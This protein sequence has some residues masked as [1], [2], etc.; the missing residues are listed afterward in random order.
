M[1]DRLRSRVDSFIR[2][3]SIVGFLYAV[4]KKF[5]EDRAGQL[6]ALVA[7]YGFFSLFPLLL[8]LITLLGIV[9]R[10]NPE[11]QDSILQ[12]ALSQLPIIGEQIREN[13][14]SIS[15]S[16]V[17]LALGIAGAVWAGLAGIKAM[18]NAM[19]TVWGVPFRSQPN[20]FK[21]LTRGTL[22]LFVLGGF[23]FVATG[24][25]AVGTQEGAVSIGLR[26]VT[27]LASLLVDVVVFLLAFRILTVADVSWRD[28][29]PGAAAAGVAWVILQT[30]GNYYVSRA[31]TGAS[32]TYGFFGIVIGLLSWLYLASQV[33]LLAAEINPVLKHRL[34]PRSLGS[35]PETDA[36]RRALERYAKVQERSKRERVE[37]TFQSRE[38]S[39]VP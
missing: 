32:E 38:T 9:L 6:A 27:F 20:V 28:V 13:V 7:Y 11:L 12:S 33:T 31:L 1:L 35:D 34:W 39:G 26:V 30:V 21:Q 2:Q 23:T 4:F 16:G 8:V 22:M 15:G 5:G 14:R 37:A 19:D 10:G 17:A 3:D 36:D 25:A 24:L 18:Q 29:F